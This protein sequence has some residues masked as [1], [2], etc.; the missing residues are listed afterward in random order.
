MSLPPSYDELL[1]GR[2]KPPSHFVAL[3]PPGA[4]RPT[5]SSVSHLLQESG[6]DVG[7]VR[8]PESADEPEAE[9]EIEAL[10]EGVPFRIACGPTPDLNELHADWSAVDRDIRVDVQ[11]SESCI[12]VMCVFTGRPLRDFHRQVKVVA[13]CAPS[14]IAA[15]DASA[16]RPHPRIWIE[17]TA[18]SSIPPSA[19]NLYV[20]HSVHHVES[21]RAPVWIHTH[22]LLRCGTIELEMM[23]VRMEE[24]Q[25]LAHLLNSVAA[26][27]LETGTPQPG[28]DFEPGSGLTLSWSPWE[29]ALED[30]SSLLPGHRA[31]RDEAHSEP[32]GVLFAPVRTILGRKLKS[33]SRLVPI[34]ENRPSLYVPMMETERQGMLARERWEVYLDLL[35][36]FHAAREWIFLAR[37]DFPADPH[38]GLER[39]GLWFHVH[40]VQGPSIDATLIN[41]PRGVPKLSEGDRGRHSVSL[42]ADWAIGT[43]MG[44]FTPDTVFELLRKLE[45]V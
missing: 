21:P 33:P 26:M 44:N 25:P 42:V 31:S 18:G 35:R 22:G 17:E 12:T 3:L 36:Q 28:S 4:E 24:T 27:F 45:R 10:V 38:S 43:P 23:N 37:L 29:E 9:W 5:F 13:A 32:S 8:R 20:I 6:L 15:L 39:E 1:S 11:N 40:G 14:L 41:A 34:L 16:C 7:C 2:Q 19:L 30:L